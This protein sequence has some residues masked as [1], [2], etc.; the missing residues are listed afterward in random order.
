MTI[1]DKAEKETGRIEAFSDGVFA[2]AITLLVINLKVSPPSGSEGLV[3]KLL[4]EWPR[5]LS[6]LTSFATILILWVNHHNLF[7]HIVRSNTLFMFLNG[8]LLF[9]ATFVPF[10]TSLVA[11]YMGDKGE[12]TAMVLYSGTML[13]MAFAYNILWRYASHHHRLLSKSVT[14]A[15]VKSINRQ[16]LVGPVFY[17]LA[18]ILAFVNV[19]ASLFLMI[20]LA[21]FFAVTASVS[22]E[23]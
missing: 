11:E 16:Y 20:L 22:R 15:Q 7:N 21:L 17:G 1:V 9:C 4:E 8:S 6:F 2:I 10:P 12:T 19:T 18:F 3:Y 23:P 14:S 5:F 13:A